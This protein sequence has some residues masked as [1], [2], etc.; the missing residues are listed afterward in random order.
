MKPSLLLLVWSLAALSSLAADRSPL[1]PLAGRTFSIQ[2]DWAGQEL[3]FIRAGDT[4][5]AVWRVLGSGVPV[6]SEVEYPLE[7]VSPRQCAFSARLRGEV[8]RK[9]KVVIGER[10]EVLLYIDGLR[11]HAEEIKRPTSP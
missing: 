2:D 5:R 8:T 1:P 7:I 3:A 4:L 9:V 11:I 10:G 6:I